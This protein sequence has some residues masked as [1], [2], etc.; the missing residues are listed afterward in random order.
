MSTFKIIIVLLT[1]GLITT[2]ANANETKDNVL[3][4]GVLNCGVSQG[5]PGFS[6]FDVSDNKWKGIDVDIC[7]AVAASIL[8]DA[9]K[10]G[11]FQTSGKTRF[12]VLKSKDIDLLVRTTTYTLT[13]DASLGVEYAGI[14]FYDGQG[15]TVRKSAKIT[16]VKQLKNANICVETG[17]TTELNMRDYFN[18]HKIKYTPIVFESQEEIIQA[19]DSGRC[20]SYS[21]DKSQLSSHMEKLKNPEDHIILKETISKEPWGP[22]VRSNEELWENIVRWSLYVMIEA[23]EYGITSENIDSF[24]NTKNPNIKRL[25]GMESSTGKLLGLSNTWSYNIIKQVG[26][27]QE[28]FDRNLGS[29]SKFKLDRGINKLWSQG[30]IL[31]A[32]PVR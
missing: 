2:Y 30:G 25:L 31:Y 27:Y 7:R 3:K 17:T 23:E 4:R 9:G 8:G 6:S 19:Y 24:K 21:S 11:F 14:N 22:V 26:N 13:R 15:F 29:K 32:P 16:S 5:N 10:V 12:E 18:A 20:D 28:S 1:M